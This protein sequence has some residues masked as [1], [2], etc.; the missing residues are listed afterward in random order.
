MGVSFGLFWT[1]RDYLAISSTDNANRN[2]YYGLESFLG[3]TCSIVVPFVVEWIV[4]G[5]KLYGWF[6]GNRNHAY[7]FITIAVF[8][9]ALLASIIVCQGNFKNPESGRF[10]YWK[11]HILKTS[12]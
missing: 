10:L 6:G 7:F 11:Y 2:Y 1:N 4:A 9:L 12:A 5:S 8:G 3:T